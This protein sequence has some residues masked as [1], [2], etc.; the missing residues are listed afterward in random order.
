MGRRD[1]H[2]HDSTVVSRERC[3]K[4]AAL[5][6]DEHGDNLAV[7]SDGHAYC[8]RGDCNYYRRSDGSE[9]D[10]SEAEISAGWTPYRT[11]YRELKR[12]GISEKTCRMFGYGIAKDKKQDCLVHVA[13]Y[14]RGDTMIAQH[15]RYPDKDF[16]WKGNYKQTEMFG[17]RLWR[18]GGK[19]LII[20][21]GEIDAMTVSQVLNHRWAVV[22]LPNGTSSALK[23]VKRN[24]EFIASFQDIILMFDM[25]DAGRKAVEE[26]VTVLP[27]GKIRIASL[28][29][30]DAN[31]CLMNGETAAI[32]K[33][34]WEAAVYSPDEIL[35]VASIIEKGFEE[36]PTT[37]YSFPFDS[38][39]EFLIGQRSGEMTLYCSGT[40]CGK[41]TFLKELAIH[42]L[43]EGRKVGLIMLEES[44]RE[45]IDDLVS[46]IISKPVRQIQSM[47]LMNQLRTQLDKPPL[48]IGIIDDLT[49]EEY[50]EAQA[51][52]KDTNLFI[53][54]HMGNN[55]MANIV[56]RMEFMA[57]GLGVDV[58]MLDHITAT[59]IGI[60]A[61]NAM[62]E[63]SQGGERLIIDSVMK[64]LRSLIAR[65]QVRVDIVSQLKKTTKSFEEG[66][67]ITLQDL[68][69][70]GSLSSVPNTVIALERNGQ[71]PDERM[72]NTTIVR[73]LKNRL[74]G[75]KGIAACLYYDQQ[76]GRLTDI[77]FAV[78]GEGD[79]VLSPA[80]DEVEEPTDEQ[81]E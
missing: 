65:T 61:A 7:F 57:C 31:D 63:D 41:T 46:L 68:R 17:Q 14:Y 5:G 4:C 18:K 51:M 12:R 53:Y 23:D 36:L 6:F 19:C 58:I 16:R 62:E 9:V 10:T 72:R 40:G 67:R 47:R 71:D 59:A 77:P 43:N 52:L 32:T 22:S 25:D 49:D 28:P 55:A 78:D 45:T 80:F 56:D 1:A 44:P 2:E 48:D 69:G 24:L 64:R 38:L 42:H 20:T 21:E 29:Y 79:V 15:I 33:A 35:H 50:F 13:P 34:R 26:V 75:R 66:D 76:T 54:D 74:T 70:S 39:S 8:F 30:K 11:V 81:D 73:V 60:M 37:V 27:P 3:P